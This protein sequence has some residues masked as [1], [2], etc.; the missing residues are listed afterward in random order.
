MALQYMSSGAGLVVVLAIA[1]AACTEHVG[2]AEPPASS[3]SAKQLSIVLDGNESS[4]AGAEVSPQ[5][6]REARVLPFV[7]RFFIEPEFEQPQIQVAV[8]SH[9]C[10]EERFGS[11]PAAIGRSLPMN[12]RATTLIGIAQPGFAVPA[13][14]CFWLP[15]AAQ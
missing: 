7:G 2:F 15:R 6:F 4:V 9:K 10:W 5:F 13:G 1:S 14:V 8:L 12:G 3:Y 11:N